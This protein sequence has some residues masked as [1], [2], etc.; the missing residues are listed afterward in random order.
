M[1]TEEESVDGGEGG[2]ADF[3]VL[4]R[5]KTMY[6]HCFKRIFD[7]LFALTALVVLSV[8]LLVVILLV[9]LM[10]GRPVFFVQRRIG[11]GNKPFSM[12]KFCSMTNARDAEGKL[13]PDAERLTA[14]G[15]FLRKSSIDELPALI[16]V[17]KGEMSLI[18][19]RPLPVVYYPYFTDEELHRHDVRG[20]LTGLAQINGR[21]RLTWEEK[22]K[23]DLEYVS[24]LS[25]WMDCRIFFMSIRK[26]LCGADVSVRQD[27][28]SGDLDAQRKPYRDGKLR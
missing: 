6:K 23:Y 26:V 22:F 12:L 20:G 1:T 8:P 18:G 4:H 11:R 19:P 10:Q 3:A 27:D 15:K 2:K 21:N 7:F 13:L 5:G 28:G 14:I 24:G 17:L 9:V 16:N 25:F